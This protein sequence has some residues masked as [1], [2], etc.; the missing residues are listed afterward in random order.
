MNI[1]KTS[2]EELEEVLLLYQDARQFMQEH[3]NP[4]QWGQSYPPRE[5]VE[6]DIRSGKSYVCEEE[7]RLLGTF[8]FSVEADPDYARIYEGEWQGEGPYGA[9]HRVA[10]PGRKKGTASFC[11]GWCLEQSGGDLRID[12]HR[13][14]IPMQTRLEKNGVVQCGI[15]CLSNGDERIAY[16]KIV[17][18]S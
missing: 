2:M 13:D 6:Q 16:E 14:N 7:G 1:R 9:M 4:N 11:I 5:I 3:G 8:Y 12:T 10:A 18:N 17:K 15:I